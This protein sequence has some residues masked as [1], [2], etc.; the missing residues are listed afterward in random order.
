[1]FLHFTRDWPEVRCGFIITLI[2]NTTSLHCDQLS[3]GK[4][5]AEE[6]RIYFLLCLLEAS[7]NSHSQQV[8]TPVLPTPSIHII[9]LETSTQCIKT[10]ISSDDVK[11][12][13]ERARHKNIF[14]SYNSFFFSFNVPCFPP[15]NQHIAYLCLA[16]RKPKTCLLPPG[17]SS[18][19]DLRDLLLSTGG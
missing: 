5:K 12:F 18:L 7:N 16:L 11:S 13:W 17:N 6:E 10:T 19:I 9:C 4:K 15:F 2:C 3:W 8:F 1:M 14:Q